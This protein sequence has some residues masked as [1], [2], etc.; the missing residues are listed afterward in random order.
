[1]NFE[2]AEI[3][4]LAGLIASVRL[5]LVELGASD[6]DVVTDGN[7]KAVNHV[8]AFGVRG[9]PQASQEAEDGR[10]GVFESIQ[11]QVEAAFADLARD[12]AVLGEHEAS[13]VVS[14]LEA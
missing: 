2:A 13:R 9:F 7:G 3:P 5:I 12:I 8:D 1:M 6:T 11:A 14:T 4:S 10:Q